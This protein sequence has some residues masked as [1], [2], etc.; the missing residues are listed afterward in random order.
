MDG[1][2][3]VGASELFLTNMLN[4]FGL[5]AVVVGLSVGRRLIGKRP[6]GWVK[7]F[8]GVDGLRVAGV[9]AAVGLIAKFSIGLPFVFGLI[10]TQ[11]STLLQIQMFSK[12]ALMILSYMS[13][14]RGGKATAWFVLL[15]AVEVL[16]AGLVNS[17][18]A[19][20]EVIIAALVG[21]A[22]AVKK[23]S[24]FIK[25]FVVLGLLQLVLQPVVSGYRM[26]NDKSAMGNYASSVLK[27]GTLMAQSFSDFMRGIN[28]SQEAT[29]QVGGVAYAMPRS[30]RSS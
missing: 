10:G 8:E 22:L 30:R 19:I 18:M 29:P 4:S 12:A 27:T 3:V 28:N 2:Y 13:A 17:K 11:S 25:G 23:M 26:M 20:L 16:T 5:L 9:L 7:H 21:R 6:Q 14:T 1:V 15:F 24:T